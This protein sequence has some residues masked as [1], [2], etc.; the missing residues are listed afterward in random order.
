[1]REMNAVGL[2]RGGAWGEA[3]GGGGREEA[4]REVVVGGTVAVLFGGE[5]GG[6]WVLRAWEGVYSSLVWAMTQRTAT[7]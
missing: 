2:G 4:W 1:M 3:G 7:G 5:G 6:R